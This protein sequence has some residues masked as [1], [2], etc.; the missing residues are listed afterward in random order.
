MNLGGDSEEIGRRLGA[1]QERIRS[2]STLYSEPQIGLERSHG[3]G[4]GSTPDLL[5]KFSQISIF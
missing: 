1:D 4:S 2:G 5:L 3:F